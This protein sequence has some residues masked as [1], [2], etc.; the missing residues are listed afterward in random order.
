[1]CGCVFA[2]EKKEI[3]PLLNY[4]SFVQGG[5]KFFADPM[6]SE[7]YSETPLTPG[8]CNAYTDYTRLRLL[9]IN[10][11]FL[12]YFLLFCVGGVGGV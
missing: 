12:F 4:T 11:V 9:D 1:M 3:S 8:M 7:L 6:R 10:D 2:Q 5:T